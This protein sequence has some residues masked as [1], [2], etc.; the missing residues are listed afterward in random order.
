M[1]S[2]PLKPCNKIGCSNDDIASILKVIDSKKEIL[3]K[4]TGTFLKVMS[5]EAF[6][7]HGI[8]PI[9]VIFDVS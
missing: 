6:T 3:N 7:K 9:V 4:E 1:P 8:N 5:A 2:K